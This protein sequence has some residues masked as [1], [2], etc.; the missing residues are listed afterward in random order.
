MNYKSK[1]WQ[2]IKL[3]KPNLNN[4]LK[5]VAIGMIIS[6]RYLNKTNKIK[7][8]YFKTFTHPTF[9]ELY[10]LFY[11]DNNTKNINKN[12][13]LNNI[14]EISLSYWIMGDGSLN[15]RDKIITLHT[16]NFNKESNI[17]IRDELNEKF[18][19]ESTIHSSIK[20]NKTYY[21]IAIPKRNLSIIQNLTN[22]Y[23]IESMKYKINN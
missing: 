14:N 12:F 16:E 15:K 10:N 8:Y 7:S 5:S 13:I 23:I 1:Y 19:L 18:N 17:I 22:N 6:D 21:M 4:Y 9:L 11:I 20:N 3:E 2:T